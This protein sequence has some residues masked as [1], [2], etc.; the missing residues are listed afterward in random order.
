[1]TRIVDGVEKVEISSDLLNPD[2]C[3]ENYPAFRRCNQ[4]GYRE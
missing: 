4:G 2:I 3:E 1:M